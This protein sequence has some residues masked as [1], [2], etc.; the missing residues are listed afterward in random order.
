MD[1]AQVGAV[2]HSR[3]VAGHAILIALLGCRSLTLSAQ[4]PST[5]GPAAHRAKSCCNAGNK[6]AL[7][8]TSTTGIRF[9]NTFQ[10]T[11]FKFVLKNSVSPKRYTFET[12]AGGV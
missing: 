7:V 1:R 12:M 10:T 8:G 11:R 5:A 9:E 3:R 4:A 6:D 2:P